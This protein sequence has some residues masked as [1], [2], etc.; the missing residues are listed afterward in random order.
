MT[1]ELRRRSPRAGRRSRAPCNGDR[2]YTAPD[3]SE[4]VLPGRALLLVRN[5]GHHMR[6]DAV[7][8]ADGDAAAGGVP[9]HPRLDGRGAVRPA[10]AGPVLQLPQPA[11]STSS[12]RRCTARTR[13]A[14]RSTCS[15]PWSRR[16]SCPP[17]TI[18]IG[19]MDEERRTSVNLEACVAPRGGAG[20]LRQHRLPGPH[21]RRD[22]HRC[23]RPA[24]WSARTTRSPAPG[25]RPTRTATSTSRCGPGSPGNAQIGKGMWAQPAGMRAMLDTKGAQPKAGANTAWVP[26]PTAATLHALHYLETDVHAVQRELA[27]RPLTDRR[28]LLVAP[29]LPDAGRRAV[30]RAEAPRA[31]DERPVDPRLRRALGRAGH[32]LLDG[33]GPR[34]RRP[35]GGPGDAAHLQP[36]DRELAAPRA[37]RRGARCATRSPGWPCWSTS[38]TPA[39]RA[40]SR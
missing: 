20:H 24:R 40:T 12:S 29:V 5:V 38:R 22:P 28:K 35:D 10:R 37:R 31:G 6:L 8:T 32:R 25:C 26:S 33:A 15:P 13:W 34:G 1:G 39:S 17:T 2:T 14:C 23:S 3:G 16:S 36:G 18:K 9:R 19:I 11:A 4:L 7:R 30:R 27:S 21:R